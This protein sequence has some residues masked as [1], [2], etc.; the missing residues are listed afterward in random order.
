MIFKKKKT[1]FF[2]QFLNNRS[3]VVHKSI[4]FFES[5]EIARSTVDRKTNT[6]NTTGS[7]GLWRGFTQHVVVI[8]ES[9]PFSDRRL[10]SVTSCSA[11]LSFVFSISG[12]WTSQLVIMKPSPILQK[13]CCVNPDI[14]YSWNISLF[15]VP[16]DLSFVCNGY[17]LRKWDSLLATPVAIYNHC[18]SC[19]Y[20]NKRQMLEINQSW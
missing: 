19:T 7:G 3:S 17:C 9:G 10:G 12:V 15:P 14:I 4:N 2:L 5:E 20:R 18:L 1:T 6:T 16:S 8:D 13:G 11:C